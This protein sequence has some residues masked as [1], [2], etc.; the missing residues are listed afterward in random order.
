M[1]RGLILGLI[2]G[3]TLIS[4]VSAQYYSAGY[5]SYSISDALNSID[6]LTMIL[7]L[8]F[9]ISFAFLNFALSKYFQ[10]NKAIAGIVA[11][12]I[13][14]GLVYWINSFGINY[15]GFDLEYFLFN[16]SD[17]IGISGELF[18]T[19]IPI[20]LTIAL[21]YFI[22][23]FKISK[24]FMVLGTLLI[25]VSFTDLV[26]EKGIVLA[27]GIILL[28][29]GIYFS[30]NKRIVNM[31]VYLKHKKDFIRRHNEKAWEDWGKSS[32]KRNNS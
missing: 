13:S 15:Y 23:V 3:V 7:L 2:L 27:I 1:K 24:T 25:L 10:D 32:W 30:K 5:G 14:L 31:K 9:I 16:L 8:V 29:V 26:Y 21:I 12:S 20:I 11:F 6:S 18:Y 22:W 19:L 28:I 17:S 4:F